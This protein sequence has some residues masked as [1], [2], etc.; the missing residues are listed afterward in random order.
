MKSAEWAGEE[1]RVVRKGR[2]GKNDF[3]LVGDMG[4]V[5]QVVGRT[6]NRACRSWGKPTTDRVQK[7]KSRE[8]L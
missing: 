7:G 5:V 6:T 4:A 3:K 1:M 2:R 8:V